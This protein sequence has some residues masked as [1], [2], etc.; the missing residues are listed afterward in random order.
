MAFAI[1]A[2]SNKAINRAGKVLIDGHSSQEARVQAI[3][4]IAHWRSCHAYP[5]NT[6]QATLRGR[7]KKICDGALVAQRLKRIPSMEAKLRLIHGM[8]LARM[9]DIGGLRAVVDT[10]SQVRKLQDK[11]SDGSLTHE[12]I[13]VD[14]YIEHPPKSGYRSVHLIYKYNNP[15]LST[16]NGLHLELQIRTRLQHAW[17]TAVEIIGT[18][19][20][21]AL[22]SSVGS[23]EWL[24]YFKVVSAAFSLLEKTPILDEFSKWTPNRIAQTCIGLERDLDVKRNLQ[25]FAI[26]ANAIISGKT[27][28]N[29]HLIILN[30]TTKM[31]KVQ[32]YGVRRLSEA[33]E[34]YA[35]AE[36]SASL[37][38]EDIQT[39]LVATD[40]VDSL[41]R[42]YPNY[43]LDSRQFISALARI[44]KL[45]S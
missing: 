7:V 22:K 41:R 43:F 23:T 34:A 18:F 31:V 9:Q 4:I 24:F 28:G 25:A 17:A 5:V 39:V 1:P 14:D 29:Y 12:L 11:Y 33:N 36:F 30:A 27:S 38:G 35:Q 2:A 40:T 8:Q 45:L 37:S 20:N 6:F 26:A 42:A 32:S 19:L 44:P 16:Y 3:A 10:I 15:T 13:D 21:Q